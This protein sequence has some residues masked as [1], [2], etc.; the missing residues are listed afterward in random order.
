MTRD[1]LSECLGMFVQR[2]KSH[3]RKPE[4]RWM[5][6]N[7]RL[8]FHT[9]FL[10]QFPQ[11]ESSSSGTRSGSRAHETNTDDGDMKRVRVTESHDRMDRASRTRLVDSGGARDDSPSWNLGRAKQGDA[12]RVDST[13]SRCRRQ[14]CNCECFSHSDASSS[15]HDDRL[16]SLEVSAVAV[17]RKVLYG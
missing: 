13:S 5:L 15:E 16:E 4:R 11:C 8:I 12:I 17:R 9:Q 3:V 7:H 2:L 1:K 6:V 14:V 10:N